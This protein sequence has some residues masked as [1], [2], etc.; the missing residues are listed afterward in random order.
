VVFRSVLQ[1]FSLAFESTVPPVTFSLSEMPMKCPMWCFVLLSLFLVGCGSSRV[2]LL[3]VDCPQCSTDG[4]YLVSGDDTARVLYYFWD[5]NGIMGFTIE[6]KL[7]VPL[8]VDWKKSALLIGTEKYDYYTEG[9]TVVSFSEA[10]SVRWGGAFGSV[11]GRT[12]GSSTAIVSVNER[13]SFIPPGGSIS[14]FLFN[15]TDQPVTFTKGSATEWRD[16]SITWVNENPKKTYIANVRVVDFSE[17]TS[18]VRFR[19]FLTYSTDEK[20]S[21]ESYLNSQF[22]VAR[23]VSMPYKAFDLLI[24][25][26]KPTASPWGS[27][28]SFFI[29]FRQW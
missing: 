27:P 8:Y 20:F 9:Q 19:L 12:S 24:N 13:V 6:N 26:S 7:K 2:Q 3:T 28:R 17:G 11:I 4:P 16:S 1:L 25:L 23:V 22:Y 15:L 5:E 14:R 10:A 21:A 29:K 18:P